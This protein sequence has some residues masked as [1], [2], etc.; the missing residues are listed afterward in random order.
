MEKFSLNFIKY[1]TNRH[2]MPLWDSQLRIV[3]YRLNHSFKQFGG[4][5]NIKM[6]FLS[7][8]SNQLKNILNSL[9]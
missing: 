3:H 9:L 2:N 6:I 4:G 1:H 8:D 5:N 7:D